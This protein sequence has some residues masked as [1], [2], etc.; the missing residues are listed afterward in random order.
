MVGA[1]LLWGGCTKRLP[2]AKPPLFSD[3]FD[4]TDGVELGADWRSTAQPGVYR[5]SDGTLAAK[6]AHNHPLWLLRKLPR[7]AVIEFDAW[8]ESP[9]GDIKVEAYGDGSS[10]ATSPEYTSTGYVF[11]HGGWRNR[12]TALCRMNEHGEDRKTRSDLPVLP[13]KHYHYRIV[14]QGGRLEWSLDGEEVLAMEDRKGLEG[15]GHE[16][17]G[18][19]DW[20]SAVRFDNLVVRP[21]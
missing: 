3:S 14:R 8:S 5:I 11:I 7:D 16:Y 17:F 6:G 18:I 15:A 9:D 1:A 12:L 19:N 21:Y 10:Y 2:P 13:G 4:R 20:E